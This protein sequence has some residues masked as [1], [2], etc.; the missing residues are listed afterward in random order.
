MRIVRFLIAVCLV[1]ATFVFQAGSAIEPK[2]APVSIHKSEGNLEVSVDGKPFFTY[3]YDT[4]RPDLRRPLIHPLHAPSGAI[5]TQM[6]EVPGKRTAHYWHT[7]LWLSHQKFTQGNNWQLD[8]DPEAKPRKYSSLLH[9]GFDKITSGDVGRFVERLE[10]DNIKGDAILVEETRTVTI[11]RRPADRR[12]I[13]FDLVLKVRGQPVTLMATPYHILAIRAVNS[14]VPAFNKDA[15]F[16]NSEGQKNPKDGAPA[17]WIDVT[18]P[19]ESKMVGVSLFN[20]PENFRHPTPCL[21]FANQTIGL[22]PTHQQPHTLA[23]K[24]SLRLRFRVLVHAGTLAEAK[25]SQ[26]YDA[27]CKE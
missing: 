16:T 23:P 11:P 5:I 19:L 18:G 21:N 7:G 2:A 14:M 17:K 10:W 9:R 4:D 8:A 12:V 27:Y 25:V 3:H 24:E 1:G 20:H 22:S 15:F 13:D 26:E 6:G